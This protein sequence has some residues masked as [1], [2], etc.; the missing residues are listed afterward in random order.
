LYCARAP[1]IIPN[2]GLERL[3]ALGDVASRDQTVERGV[4]RFAS[5]GGE[6]ADAAQ[7]DPEDRG[8]AAGEKSSTAEQGAVAAEGHE[9][10]EVAPLEH[11][12]RAPPERREALLAVERDPAGRR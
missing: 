5:G 1:G 12:D 3:A 8:L 2:G 4:E 9:R 10:V 11:R 7:I 6:E